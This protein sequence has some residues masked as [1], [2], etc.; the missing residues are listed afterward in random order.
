MEM[1][2]RTASPILDAIYG[3][4]TLNSLKNFFLRDKIQKYKSYTPE[5]RKQYSDKIA[6]ALGNAYVY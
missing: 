2:A 6:K 1:D 3:S 5:Q 4:G